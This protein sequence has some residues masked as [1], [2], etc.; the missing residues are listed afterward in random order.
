MLM[1]HP[2]SLTLKVDNNNMYLIGLFRELTRDKYTKTEQY[3]HMMHT[4]WMLIKAQFILLFF[5]PFSGMSTNVHKS[6]HT[7]P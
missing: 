5:D 2:V 1:L 7:L 4:Q 3:W 6:L